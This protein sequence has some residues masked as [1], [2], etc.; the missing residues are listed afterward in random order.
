MQSISKYSDVIHHFEAF[1]ELSLKMQ[2]ISQYSDVMH[3]FEAFFEL[4]LKMHLL[5][6]TMLYIIL[7][8]FS[9]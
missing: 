8:H 4:S 3:H 7:V 1:F 9:T 6:N 2:S 5:Q